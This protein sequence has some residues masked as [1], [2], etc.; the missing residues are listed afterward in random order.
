[1]QRD[2][3]GYGPEPPNPAWSQGA[4]LA[5][6]FVINVEE[7]AEPSIADGD[8]YTESRLTEVSESPVAAGQR[9]LAAESM[10]EFGSR[11]GFWRLHRLFREREMPVTVFGCAVALERN[12][13]IAEAVRRAGWDVCCHGLRWVEHYKLDEAEERRQIADAVARIEKAVGERP[14]GWY[15]RYGPSVNTRRLLVEEGG[16]VYD[17]DAYNDELPYWVRQSGRA[18]L[19]VPYSLTHND[20]QFVRGRIANGREFFEFLRD[21]FDF[22]YAESET[23]PRM[24]SVGLHQRV[25]GHPG[26][27]SGLADFL[28][29]VAGHEEVWVCRRVDLARHWRA[30]FPPEEA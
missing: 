4:R 14:L 22:L 5:L 11:V 29:H 28:D 23:T 25:V 8:G 1:M 27:A 26:R 13:A 2:F 24:M 18:H 30:T 19:V 21:A 17:S 3:V 7:G 10:F 9:D 15:C 12:P 20:A 16:F 6:N